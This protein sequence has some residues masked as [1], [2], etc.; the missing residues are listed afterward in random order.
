MPLRVRRALVSVARSRLPLTPFDS[1]SLT[2]NS[3]YSNRLSAST[4]TELLLLTQ[5]RVATNAKSGK[6]RFMTRMLTI[7]HTPILLVMLALTVLLVA[8]PTYQAV[9]T[10][11]PPFPPID[12]HPD[13]TTVISPG[14]TTSTLSGPSPLDLMLVTL[15][16]LATV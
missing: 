10:D 12:T 5:I 4:G 1:E 3:A 8:S 11:V 16:A 13:T 7:R 9:A 14:D 6:E 15:L 2:P